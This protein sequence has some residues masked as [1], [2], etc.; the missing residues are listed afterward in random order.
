MKKK[1][2]NFRSF[3]GY[4]LEGTSIKSDAE[5]AAV[6]FVHGITSDRDELG[7]HA[8]YA[9]FLSEY[10]V[11]SLRF[12]YRYH[13]VYEA[14]LK[15]LTLT[16]IMNDID[17]AYHCLQQLANETTNS[18]F[19]VGTSFGGGLSAFWVNSQKNLPIKMV[20][21]NA[22]VLDYQDDVLGRNGLVKNEHLTR[23][24]QKALEKD[25]FVNSS[26]IHFGGALINELNFIDGIKPIAEL[27]K[28]VVIFH[29]RNDDDVP[30]SSSEKFRTKDTRLEIIENV[31]HG[32]GVVDDEDLDFP[33]TKAIHRKIY[34]KAL[35][36]IEE[37]L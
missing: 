35:T 5:K 30:L 12:D 1:I 22:P 26:D 23:N 7:F 32:F 29:G 9:T 33:E 25:G 16:G 4:K 14:S 6:L 31:G 34:E 18:F 19:I 11:T 36:I 27:G 10:G 21:L 2:V 15:H 8:D 37:T 24:A 13:G 20:I 28:R 17:A 3:D